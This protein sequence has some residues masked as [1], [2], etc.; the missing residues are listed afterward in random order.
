LGFSDDTVLQYI[1]RDDYKC[2]WKPVLS[3]LQLQPLDFDPRYNL[4]Y[5]KGDMPEKLERGGLPYYLPIGWYRHA[6]KVD[7]KYKDGEV[8]LGSSNKKGEWPVAFHGTRSLAVKSIAD[9]GLLTGNVVRDR[10][11]KEAIE[12][13]GEAVNRPGLYVATHCNGG[14]HPY[15]TEKFEVPT[16]AGEIEAF[17]V[18][19]QCRVRPGSYTVHTAPVMIGEAWRVV[20]PEDV[21][22]Y[23][24]LLKNTNLKVPFEEDHD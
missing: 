4:D 12:Q 17:Q 20:D 13:K 7:K 2:K 24:I 6:L 1:K 14:S 19:F 3:F 10:M 21:R 9:K 8:W 22:P 15:Y 5:A 18:V 11:L 16:P 23:G